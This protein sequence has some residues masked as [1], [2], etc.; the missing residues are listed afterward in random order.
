V[1]LTTSKSKSF[2]VTFDWLVIHECKS[3]AIISLP[4]DNP[5]ADDG[6]M[7]ANVEYQWNQNGA[8]ASL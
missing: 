4:I 8:L 3:R 2:A 5:T 7:H 1:V 6:L